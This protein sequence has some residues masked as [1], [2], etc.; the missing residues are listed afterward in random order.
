[1]ACLPGVA[2]AKLIT[3]IGTSTKM[4]GLLHIKLRILPGRRRPGL[5]MCPRRRER[6]TVSQTRRGTTSS[7]GSA[8]LGAV[9]PSWRVPPAAGVVPQASQPIV[10]SGAGMRNQAAQASC[11]CSDLRGGRRIL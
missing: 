10:N 1:M 7:T 4:P 6:A 8:R 11:R 9:R 2:A 5:V 3:E